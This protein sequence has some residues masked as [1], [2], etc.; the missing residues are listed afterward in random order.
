M[1]KY[2]VQGLQVNPECTDC[3]MSQGCD[4]VNEMGF[5]NLEADIMVVSKMPN[6]DE[7]H[8]L[9][10]DS[11]QNVGINSERCY[12]T[13]ALKCRNFEVTAGRGAVKACKKYLE[14][15]IDEV[16][17]KWILA[18]GNEALQALTGHSGITK[19]RAKPMAFGDAVVIATVSPAAINRNPGQKAGWL[20]DIRFF[21][22]QVLGVA[23]R[24]GKPGVFFVDTKEKFQQ[25]RKILR[26]TEALCYDIETRGYEEYFSGSSI[27]SLSGTSQLQDGR[28]ITWALPLSHPQSPFRK[29]WQE[30]LRRLAPDL[31]AISKHI[32]H[33]GK[34]DARWMRHFGVRM[35]VTFDTMLAVH[36]LNENELKGL[37]SQA[38][39][40]FGVEAWA[41]DTRDL[42]HKPIRQVLEYNALDTW[43]TYHLYLEAKK[44]L[45][46]QPRLLRVF[47]LLIMPACELFIEAERRGIWV[48][49]ER[50]ATNTHIA[51]R[52]RKDI[53]DKM[54]NFVPH[55][56]EPNEHC[57]LCVSGE[58][59]TTKE[60]PTN[61]K[62]RPVEVNF[63]PSNFARW[64]LFNH[65]GLPILATGKE[66]EDGSEGAPSMAEAIMLELKGTHPVV[67]LYLERTKWQKYCT[68]FLPAI[69]EMMDE[70]DRVHTTF[71]QAGTVT[72][73]LS[74]GKADADKVTAR[75]DIRGINIQQ[76][77]RDTFIRG[78]YGSA[79]G[80]AFVECDF[81]QVELRVV[82]HLAREPTMLHLYST[83]QDIHRATASW[84]MGVPK[85]RVTKDD[86]KKAK[87]VNF[88]F[89]YG[90][91]A[92]KFVYTAFEKYELH[93][94]LQEAEQIRKIFFQ[95]FKGLLPWHARQ[96]RIVRN[97]GRV[98]SPIGRIRHLPDIFSE[99]WKVRAEAER[100][101]INS[102][103]QSFASDMN[104]LAMMET[105]ERFKEQG[106][107][108]Y[109][110]G[111]IHDATLFEIRIRDLRR[112][113]P[114]IKR[115]F[116]NLPLRKRFGVHL[117]VPI[118]ADIKVGRHWGDAIEL[119]E[120]EVYD[121]SHRRIGI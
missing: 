116:E 43:Y 73:R 22:S 36:L 92:K 32:A 8:K 51:E 70:H 100:Q 119:T 69:A 27:V 55:Q 117:D 114:I 81:S 18:F 77:P 37:K 54:R 45:I 74:S 42:W 89:V 21:A 49:R 59:P 13:A 63:N 96:R 101:A 97:Y 10:V 112:A 15:E 58:H 75:V 44:E 109:P 71:K 108:G 86:R 91:G 41:I 3:R 46:E 83:G 52:M 85:D 26:R 84:V 47:K 1:G 87:A 106:I 118:V 61:A 14:D 88:G 30:A 35:R 66:K 53:E 11:L 98:Q 4:W 2:R 76:T 95:Q 80:Y 19:Y 105:V 120:E 110:L 90:M 20:A 104:T 56:P 33:N 24:V 115:T 31:E 111:T 78:L 60:W 25:L 40:R 102:P 64:W 50:L 68:A 62:G 94:T 57:V 9:I 28:T 99:D 6:S 48:D 113:L 121:Y 65:L 93:F 29:S 72:G 7:Y 12:F 39:S 5:G 79:P 103:V 16:K 38:T 107:E 82:A 17:P 23:A 67:D 34:F